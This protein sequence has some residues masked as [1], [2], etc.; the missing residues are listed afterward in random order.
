M[1]DI[2]S[3]AWG[4]LA[5]PRHDD[6]AEFITGSSESRWQLVRFLHSHFNFPGRVRACVPWSCVGSVGLIPE[7]PRRS[8]RRLRQFSNEST[9]TFDLAAYNETFANSG[10]ST[11]NLQAHLVVV[12]DISP[13]P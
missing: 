12:I 6:Y 4:Q 7:R 1:V 9:H 3:S 10:M 8:S 5:L 11:S 2:G 13:P